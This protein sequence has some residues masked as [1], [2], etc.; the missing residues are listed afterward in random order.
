MESLCSS[1]SVTSNSLDGV[2]GDV[3]CQGGDVG[4][5]EAVEAPTDAIII[6]G[7]ELLVGEAEPVRVVACGPLADAVEGLARDEQVADEQKQ[8]RGR[9]DAG[10]PILAREVFAEEFLDAEPFEEAIEDRQGAD[11]P[12]F[13][14]V[15]LGVCRF[16]WPSWILVFIHVS[17]SREPCRERV[18]GRL[19]GIPRP[20]IAGGL[21]AAF[22]AD[23]IAGAKVAVKSE[24]IYRI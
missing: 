23:M 4:V 13:E 16:P 21:A 19:A 7:G 11:P 3:E 22:S 2:G 20:E 8:G 24:K 14:G 17:R 10:P 6:E 9:G 5:E 18:R 15:S 12:R 1:S